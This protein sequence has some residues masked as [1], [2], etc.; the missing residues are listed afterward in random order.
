MISTHTKTQKKHTR[1]KSKQARCSKK[2]KQSKLA[3]RSRRSREEDKKQYLP[4][5]S[6]QSPV[7]HAP[8]PLEFPRPPTDYFCTRSRTHTQN[9]PELLRAFVRQ[10]EKR[11]G[12]RTSSHSL[13]QANIFSVRDYKHTRKQTEAERVG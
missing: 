11:N 1:S 12:K 8:P 2:Q 13:T 7:P 10:R 4:S 5:S 9:P 6:S 3:K